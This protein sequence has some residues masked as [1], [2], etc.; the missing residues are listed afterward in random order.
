MIKENKNIIMVSAII[1]ILGVAG[2][3]YTEGIADTRMQ[4]KD[5]GDLSFFNSMRIKAAYAQDMSLKIFALADKEKLSAYTA[6]EGNNI[7][8]ERGIVIGYL[9]AEMMKEEKL[10]SK[11]GDKIDNLFGINITIV[12]ILEKTDTIIDDI[13][14]VSSQDYAKVEGIEG[15]LYI[16][17]LDKT[18]K[19]FYKLDYGERV[20]KGFELAEGKIEN[21]GQKEFNGKVYHPLI[22]GYDEAQMMREERLFW[23]IDDRIDGFFGND[24][25]IA[26]ILKKSNTSIDMLHFLPLGEEEI[27]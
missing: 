10:F 7:P 25:F 12:G 16:R 18:P 15:K 2:Y 20:P 11:A 14:F 5:Y 23:K 1:L 17:L 22:I 21:Y 13:H 3:Y 8:S 27:I 26:G 4:Q 6:I 24:V 19:Y 9:E